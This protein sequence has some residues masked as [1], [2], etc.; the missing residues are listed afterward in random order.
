MLSAAETAAVYAWLNEKRPGMIANLSTI[1]LI[2]KRYFGP[3]DWRSQNGWGDCA[4]FVTFTD[5]NIT[6]S[7]NN[8]LDAMLTALHKLIGNVPEKKYDMRRYEH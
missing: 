4:I 7:S 2:A 5:H 8:S 6:G 3:M 1:R